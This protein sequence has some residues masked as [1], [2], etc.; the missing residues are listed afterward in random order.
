MAY[1]DAGAYIFGGVAVGSLISAGLGYAGFG[2]EALT[3]VILCGIAA[4]YLG[5]S[6]AKDS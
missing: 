4:Y 2:I 6:E 1:K 5:K 3:H